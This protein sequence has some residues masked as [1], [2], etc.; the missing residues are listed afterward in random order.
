MRER[1]AAPPADASGNGLWTVS[2]LINV[3]S[4]VHLS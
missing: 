4:V 2:F 3:D 1:G